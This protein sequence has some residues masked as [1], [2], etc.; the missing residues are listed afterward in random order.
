MMH[1]TFLCILLKQETG[2]AGL[3]WW[4]HGYEMPVSV[5]VGEVNEFKLHIL[6]LE[7]GPGKDFQIESF[8]DGNSK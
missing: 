4:Y 1:T 3:V 7:K 2:R 8:R 5:G 6:E